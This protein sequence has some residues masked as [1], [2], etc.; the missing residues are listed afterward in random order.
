MTEIVLTMHVVGFEYVFIIERSLY[1]YNR[2]RLDPVKH[3]A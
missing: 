1:R 2:Q 3:Y